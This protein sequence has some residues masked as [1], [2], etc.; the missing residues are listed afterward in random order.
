MCGISGQYSIDGVSQTSI[1]GSVKEISHRGPDEIG[2]YRGQ[3]CVLGMCRLAIIDVKQGQQPNYDENRQIVSIFNGEIYNF[4]ELRQELVS[5]RYQ[6]SSQGDSALIPY[7]YREY[8][9]KFLDKIQGMF[10]I[11]V[12]DTRTEKL[13]LARDRLGKK[14]LWYTSSSTEISFSSEL[15]GLFALGV[16]RDV[17]LEVI[18][19]YLRYGYINSPRSAFKDIYQ[20]EPG[21]YLIYKNG[22]SFIHEY[23][24]C[25]DV[26]PLEI[27]F[28]DA[29]K[30]AKRLIRDSVRSRLVSERPIGSFLSGGIDSTIITAIM[31]QESQSKVHSFSIG[32]DDSKFDESKFASKV[33]NSIGTQH[34]EKIVLP[35]PDL[36]IGKL[37]KVLD[38][39]FA[40]SSII[41]TYLLSEFAS[42]SVVVALSGDG[43]DE[44]FAGYE[45]YR[46]GNVL[47]RINPL[48]YL[49]PLG[50]LSSDRIQN[51][52]I[53]KLIKHSS[54]NPLVNRYKGFQ[55]L[56]TAE[57]LKTL[58]TRDLLE[59][60]TNDHFSFMWDSISSEN[61]IRHM[62]EMDIKS[63]LPGDLMY[64][65]DIASMANSLEVRSPFLDYRIVEFG[66]SLPSKFKI[67]NRETKHILREIA[68]ELV[69]SSLINRPKMGFGIPRGRWIREDLR[70]LV[71]ETTLGESAK[72]R[73]WIN[74]HEFRKI[75]DKHDKG[76]QYDSVIWPIFML[77]LWAINWIDQ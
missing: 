8:G 49:N 42:Q 17:N 11:A 19:E 77:E 53:R 69:P 26:K 3:N 65:V 23:W 41:P 52:R 22:I 47:Q 63:Y 67:G 21:H 66:L 9:E 4:E 14:P 75:L 28:E 15:K 34:H 12:Y 38:Q 54:P 32:F 36:L 64:K 31:Q 25:S 16:Q 58:L 72:R 30:E 5:K 37:A 39:P 73:G 46:A 45:R 18:S 62:Q 29:K 2:F 55:S 76:F 27:S 60:D 68:R 40:D 10:A 33:A 6:I 57:N 43:G 74:T 59:L 71:Y 61:I 56:L 13:L 24:K 20:L 7:L 70:D 51:Q 44:A 35:E 50:I 48:L 1:D